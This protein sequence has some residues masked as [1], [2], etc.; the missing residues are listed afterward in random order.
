MSEVIC[1]C[2][3]FEVCHIR[4]VPSDEVC[5]RG[6][7]APWCATMAP[8]FPPGGGLEVWHRGPEAYHRGLCGIVPPMVTM[9]PRCAMA[10]MCATGTEVCHG[11]APRCA[12]LWPLGEVCHRDSE[13]CHRDSEACHRGSEVCHRGSEV[14]HRDSDVCH[15][16]SEVWLRGVAPRRG[17]EAWLRGVAPRRGSEVWLRAIALVGCHGLLTTQGRNRHRMVTAPNTKTN[18]R[19]S[20]NWTTQ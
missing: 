10:P 11:V 8:R 16:G 18:Y 6:P 17:P 14:C 15:H 12:K 20:V 1:R 3:T 19:V 13:V 2:A 7:E 4:G 5:R 9:V